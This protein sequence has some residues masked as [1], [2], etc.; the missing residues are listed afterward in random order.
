MAN[1]ILLAF[2]LLFGCGR[3]NLSRPFTLSGWTYE[4]CLSRGKKIAYDRTDIGCVVAREK[5]PGRSLVGFADKLLS[6]M[7]DQSGWRL[8]KSDGNAESA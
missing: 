1:A 3:Q 6:A 2:D 5:S 4:V 7:R 8:E